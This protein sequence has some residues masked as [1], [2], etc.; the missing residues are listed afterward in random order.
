MGNFGIDYELHTRHEPNTHLEKRII[1]ENIDAL[2]KRVYGQHN[3]TES[4]NYYEESSLKDMIRQY[5]LGIFYYFKNPTIGKYWLMKS[6]DQGYGPACTFIGI[7]EWEN[8]NFSFKTEHYLIKGHE[9]GDIK[10]TYKLAIG[11]MSRYKWYLSKIRKANKN[12][13]EIYAKKA[14]KLFKIVVKNVGINN[15]DFYLLNHYLSNHY[16][17]GVGTKK[18]L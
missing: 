5:K 17:Y 10:A 3:I 12:S 11:Y 2:I 4:I 13:I 18:I 8:G 15:V 7:K 14:F 1:Y 9:Y 6:A 16:L